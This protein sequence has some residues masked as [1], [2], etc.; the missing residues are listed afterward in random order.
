MEAQ[1]ARADQVYSGPGKTTSIVKLI[2][3]FKQLMRNNLADDPH[4]RLAALTLSAGAPTMRL[5]SVRN[6]GGAILNEKN[7]DLSAYGC[8]YRFPGLGKP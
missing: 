8:V 5:V 1:C 2:C 6:D 4:L 3:G 7:P